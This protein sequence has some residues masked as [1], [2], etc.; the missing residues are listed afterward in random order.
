MQYFGLTYSRIRTHCLLEI[1]VCNPHVCV[2][3]AGLCVY[4]SL[5]VVCIPVNMY[6]YVLCVYVYLGSSIPNKSFALTIQAMGKVEIELSI[7]KKKKKQ[8]FFSMFNFD[9]EQGTTK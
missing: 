9:S 5:G 2:L 8:I 1:Q 7:W 3:C 6:V 4:S